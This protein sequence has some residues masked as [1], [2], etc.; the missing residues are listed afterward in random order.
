M[1]RRSDLLVT[2]YSK[3]ALERM[4]A[5]LARRGNTGMMLMQQ[6]DKDIVGS[7]NGM[8]TCQDAS[9]SSPLAPLKMLANSLL[10]AAP[11]YMKE[12][13]HVYM[14]PPHPHAF[15]RSLIIF[16]GGG[17]PTQ[18]IPSMLRRDA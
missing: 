5:Q 10:S 6:Y 12:G 2:C 9:R 4:F 14:A 15:P 13:L 16:D 8:P 17:V 3:A 18:L 1:V 7:T 11:P